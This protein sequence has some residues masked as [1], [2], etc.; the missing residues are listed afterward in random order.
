M[1]VLFGTVLIDALHAAF[2][3]REITLDGIG[4]DVAANVLAAR[5]IDLLMLGDVQAGIPIKTAFVGVKAALARDVLNNYL[6]NGCLVRAIDMEGAGLPP[7]STRDTIARL[8]EGLLLP[9]LVRFRTTS[10]SPK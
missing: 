2:E 5:M 4:G 9:F 8:P 7:R 10:L 3:N 6:G 1:Q